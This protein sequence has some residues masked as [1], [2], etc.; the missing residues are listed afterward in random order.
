MTAAAPLAGLQT[1]RSC[2]CRATGCKGIWRRGE[3][4]GLPDTWPLGMPRVP[5]ASRKKSLFGPARGGALYARVCNVSSTNDAFVSN[6]ADEDGGAIAV[7]NSAQSRLSKLEV[8]A[9]VGFRAP[10][11]GPSAIHLVR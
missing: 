7:A 9:C 3:R 6:R 1:L 4:G 10:L 8:S 2:G 11:Q 5:H